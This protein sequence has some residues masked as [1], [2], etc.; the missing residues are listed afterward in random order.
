MDL[1]KQEIQELQTELKNKRNLKALE[2]EWADGWATLQTCDDN[3]EGKAL[4][5]HCNRVMGKIILLK[6]E[7]YGL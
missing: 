7:L 5:K 6:Q 1:T 4:Q 2:K 3:S